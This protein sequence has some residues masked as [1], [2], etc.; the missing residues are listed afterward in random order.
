[1]STATP[2]AHGFIPRQLILALQQHQGSPR[3]PIVKPGQRVFKGQVLAHGGPLRSASLHASTSGRVRAIEE[4]LIP[5]VHEIH[6]S[7]CI[8]IDT[9]GE[10]E[11]GDVVMSWPSDQMEQLERIRD[12]GIVG[13]GGAVF[14][15]AE[16][17]AS[18]VP[19]K[20]LIVNGAECEPYISC[21]DMLMREAPEEIVAGAIIM[22]D[23]LSAAS[24]IFAVERDKPQAIQAIGDAARAID[25]DRLRLAEIPTIY[26]AGGERQ[27]V[28]MLIGEEVPS[29]HY[30]SEI[31]YVCQNVGTAF[32]V[33]RLASAGEPLISRIVT[34]TGN[35]I[36]KPQN[37]EV[38]IGTPISELMEFCGGYR[39]DVA[40]LILGG[41]M[42]GY[43]LPSDE[44]PITKASNCLIA[45]TGTEVRQDFTERHCIRCGNC[46]TACPARLLPQELLRAARD[47]DHVLLDD[48]GLT[49]CIECGCC[50]VICP[51]H[52]PL[53]E[54]FR[55]AKYAE[56]RHERQLILSAESEERFQRREQRQRMDAERGKQLQDHLKTEMQTDQTSRTKAIREAIERSRRRRNP[57]DGE[58]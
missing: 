54:I 22:R 55:H 28:E 23:L 44:L 17:L 46:G 49:D 30:P 56:A 27:L 26:P 36:H 29:T 34:V 13:L 47:E 8:V 37:V 20:A 3:R 16:K 24:C 41:S 31:G 21:D 14:P 2:I 9:D 33:Q 43:A 19:C 48:L 4:R 32:A 6:R 58:E 1:M 42:M 45:A 15:T 51:S 5:S 57:D 18:R 53:T 35:G 25:D 12:G 11:S 39:N 40:R 10:D 52:I 38:L 50:D 7:M